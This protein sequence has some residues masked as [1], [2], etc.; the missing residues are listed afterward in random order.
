LPQFILYFS[1]YLHPVFMEQTTVLIKKLQQANSFHPVVPFNPEQDRLLRMDFTAANR[2]MDEALLL[3]TTAFSQYVD[4]LLQH[5]SC[6]Y[7]IGGYNE[8]RT[9]YSRSNV[10][11]ANGAKEEPRRL[12]LGID[13]WGKAGTPVFA[14]L[15]GT[16]HSFAFN[17]RFGDYGATI[18]VRH[19]IEGELF[20][21]LYGHLSLADLANLTKGKY[22]DAGEV[23]GHFGEAVENGGWPPHLH[24]QIIRDMQQNRGDYPGVCRYS[25]RD[26]YLSNCPDPD[27]ILRLMQYAG[28]T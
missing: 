5:H 8:H 11:D 26:Y 25:E 6:T 15:E 14:P 16:V 23:I 19:Q 7:G 9:I 2:D 24:I 18:I 22:I 21:I 27:L 20:H 13:V 1:S 17:D 4:S 12:H 10:F 28:D 3:N